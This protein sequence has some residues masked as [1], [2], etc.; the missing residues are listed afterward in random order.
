MRRAALSLLTCS[1]GLAIGGCT[2]KVKVKASTKPDPYAGI[3]NDQRASDPVDTGPVEAAPEYPMELGSAQ[4]LGRPSLRKVELSMLACSGAATRVDLNDLHGI[5]RKEGD[6]ECHFL[7][8]RALAVWDNTGVDRAPASANLCRI[9]AKESVL[10]LACEGKA[11]PDTL[12]DLIRQC[13]GNDRTCVKVAKTALIAKDPAKAA[14][15]R[16][17]R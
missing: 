16:N 13:K 10:S 2:A 6:G 1:I 3:S 5:C 7:V 12:T 9:R 11:A 8:H 4:C 15:F 17:V 14:K